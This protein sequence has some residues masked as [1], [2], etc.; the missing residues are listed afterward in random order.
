MNNYRER[1]S[2]PKRK[3]FSKKGSCGFKANFLT[4]DNTIQGRLLDEPL[5]EWLCDFCC[6]DMIERVALARRPMSENAS[7]VLQQKSSG[8][9]T[10]V[11]SLSDNKICLEWCCP[12]VRLGCCQSESL[13]GVGS[14]RLVRA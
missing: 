7:K 3:T 10:L 1:G 4:K 5:S 12:S 14:P 11:E 13:E 2:E 9:E 6:K 8:Q